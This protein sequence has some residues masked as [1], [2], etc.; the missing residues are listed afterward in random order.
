MRR[1]PL[2]GKPYHSEK[3]S[4]TFGHETL[5]LGGLSHSD[6]GPADLIGTGTGTGVTEQNIDDI[7]KNTSVNVVRHCNGTGVCP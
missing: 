1:R 7:I 4:L 3:G 6:G 5:H 2:R